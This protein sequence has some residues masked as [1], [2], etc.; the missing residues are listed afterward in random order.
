MEA[1]ETA[2]SLVNKTSNKKNLLKLSWT[3]FFF[4]LIC[5]TPAFLLGRS[6][7]AFFPICS[8]FFCLIWLQCDCIWLRSKHLLGD[9]GRNNW[10]NVSIFSICNKSRAHKTKESSVY[11][12]SFRVL[13][14]SLCT[15]YN[16]HVRSSFVSS[17]WRQG[18]KHV[19]SVMYG[20]F[21]RRDTKPCWQIELFYVIAC[22]NILFE[23]DCCRSRLPTLVSFLMLLAQAVY[24]GSF[25]HSI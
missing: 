25:S 5:F 22:S 6:W 11:S 16:V 4:S 8:L 24:C 19:T 12:I 21:M 14:A 2:A 3:S 17:H 23:N 9:V 1:T 10:R 7:F 13:S 15:L 20:S 18:W